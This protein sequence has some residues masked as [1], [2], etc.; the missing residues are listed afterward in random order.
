MVAARL[1]LSSIHLLG[2][3]GA[4]LYAASFSLYHQYKSDPLLKEL[5]SWMIFLTQ[6]LMR[7]PY[8]VFCLVQSVDYRLH[9]NAHFLPGV[10]C[11]LFN[12]LF[13]ALSCRIVLRVTTRLAH[14]SL[15]GE[16]LSKQ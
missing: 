9:V 12:C 8:S 1:F 13:L 3:S 16:Q 2:F 14:T 10:P 7:I 4:C 5:F 6:L 15:F 11:A